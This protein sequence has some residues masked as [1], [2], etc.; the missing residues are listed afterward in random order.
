MRL[1]WDSRALKDLE[2]IYAHIAADN[3]KAARRVVERIEDSIGRLSIMPMS[4]RP[5]VTK[6][7]RLLAVPGAPYIVVHRV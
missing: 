3:P 6:A 4:G 1:R 7:T 2:A 5:G